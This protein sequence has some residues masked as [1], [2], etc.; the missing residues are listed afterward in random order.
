[1]QPIEYNRAT[2][3]PKFKIYADGWGAGDVIFY[4]PSWF[5]RIWEMILSTKG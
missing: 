3:L 2:D 5:Q 1:M 4:E